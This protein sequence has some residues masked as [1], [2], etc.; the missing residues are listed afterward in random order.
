MGVPTPRTA[1]EKGRDTDQR[2]ELLER[3]LGALPDRLSSTGQQV[4]DWDDAM[5]AGNYWS[6]TSA[7][8]NPIGNIAS[9]RVR[10]WDGSTKRITQEIG[11]PSTFAVNIGAWWQRTWV[12]TTGWGPWVV[13]GVKTLYRSS[14]VLAVPTA[15]TAAANI[16]WDSNPFPFLTAGY[17]FTYGGSGV[18]TC[19]LAGVYTVAAQAAVGTPSAPTPLVV[20]LAVNGGQVAA[21]R[22]T[23][24]ASGDTVGFAPMSWGFA[25]G[26]TLEIRVVRGPTGTVS[27]GGLIAR[28]YLTITS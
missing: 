19:T 24:D 22:M 8:N 18:F 16:T 3:R 12:D 13:Y 20:L 25:V 5:A 6:E 15:S 23:V 2:I 9:G 28:T 11:I 21:G 26:D 27:L 14:S 10:V 7:L 4:T 17:G 1:V